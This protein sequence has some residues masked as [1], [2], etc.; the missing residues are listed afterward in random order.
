MLKW[1][2]RS[3]VLRVVIVNSEMHVLK[4]M[5]YPDSAKLSSGLTVD[6]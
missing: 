3:F 4:S 2:A 5:Y 1:F 6:E